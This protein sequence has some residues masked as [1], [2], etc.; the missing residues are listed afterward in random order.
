MQ[1]MEILKRC[2]LMLSEL[3]IRE[4]KICYQALTRKYGQGSRPPHRSL[5]RTPFFDCYISCF[6]KNDIQSQIYS[7]L[8]I[9]HN[10][11]TH[12][13]CALTTWQPPHDAIAHRRGGSI[14]YVSHNRKTAFYYASDYL[15][16]CWSDLAPRIS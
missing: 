8:M 3:K 12:Y 5:R 13:P 14:G 6:L 16:S 15:P 11:V 1:L 7:F 4:D 9:G 2:A 10:P